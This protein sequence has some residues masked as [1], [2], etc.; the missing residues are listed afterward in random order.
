MATLFEYIDESGQDTGGFIFLVGIVIVD[1]LK[2]KILPVLEKIEIE[3][4]KR[5]FKWR[6]AHWRYRRAYAERIV[7]IDELKGALFCEIFRDNKEYLNMTATAAA[8]ALRQR[9]ADRAVVYIDG[10]RKTEVNKFKKQFRPSAKIPVKVS[11]VKK[12][13]N[14]ALIRLADAVCGLVRDAHEGDK[15]AITAVR[16]LKRRDILTEL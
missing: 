2:E 4:K 7:D 10:F 9:K 8:D 5:N 6:P 11:G 12:E 16:R 13:E 14:N 1:S 3:T 15:W